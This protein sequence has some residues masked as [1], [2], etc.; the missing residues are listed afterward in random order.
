M[1]QVNASK[2]RLFLNAKS[3]VEIYMTAPT[4]P[5]TSIP[6]LGLL[7]KQLIFYLEW[8]NHTHY[9]SLTLF[10]LNT[11]AN[12]FQPRNLL[13]ERDLWINP[14][15]F[16]VVVFIVAVRLMIHFVNSPGRDCF[17]QQSHRPVNMF[18]HHCHTYTAKGK[19]KGSKEKKILFHTHSFGLLHSLII[20]SK[21]RTFSFT[22]Y[23][24]KH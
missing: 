18:L 14:H 10:N 16:P 19:N 20:W 21:K 9:G 15:M 3:P 11:A 7:D 2:K 17:F 23:I 1:C 12:F 13:G 4:Q 8:K 22:R 24:E 6:Q 5:D